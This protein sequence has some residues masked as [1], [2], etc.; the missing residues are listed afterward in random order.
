MKYTK[1]P[2]ALEVMS[3]DLRESEALFTEIFPDAPP[4]IMWEVDSHTNN[5]QTTRRTNTIGGNSGVTS[6]SVTSNGTEL[7]FVCQKGADGG[8]WK[9][10]WVDQKNGT[11]LPLF[12]VTRSTSDI[13]RPAV[14]N[15]IL[16][17]TKV[18]LVGYTESAMS[19]SG[20]GKQTFTVV[21]RAMGEEI[22]ESFNDIVGGV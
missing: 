5:E 6:E 15:E 2:F 4:R 11:K 1:N 22:V 9:R 14:G 3:Q 8:R 16:A 20:T 19:G 12:T 17:Y 21:L 7:T 10:R 18:S 13:V